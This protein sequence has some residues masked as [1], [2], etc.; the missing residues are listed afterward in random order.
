MGYCV[1]PKCSMMPVHGTLKSRN[2]SRS[3]VGYQPYGIFDERLR[4]EAKAFLLV[5]SPGLGSTGCEDDK[6]MSW[7]TGQSC[8]RVP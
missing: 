4:E 8:V 6:L 3:W 5:C 2:I 1:M 7:G